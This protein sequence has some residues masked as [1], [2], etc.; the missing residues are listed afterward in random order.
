MKTV[1]ALICPLILAASALAVPP[2]LTL[3][4]EV[5]GDVTA[6]IKI[7]AVTTGKTVQW[8]A[9]DPGLNVFP[10][11]QLKDTKT[12]IVTSARAGRYRMLAYTALADEVSEPAICV[13]VVGQPPPEPGPGPGPGPTPPTPPPSPAPIP[14]AGLHVLIVENPRERANLKPEQL[15]ILF[16]KKFHDYLNSKCVD[17]AEAGRKAWNIWTEKTDVS[18]IPKK[19]Q[20]AMKR[21]RK[22]LPWIIISNPTK[23]GFEGPLPENV[24]K[25][26]ELIKKYE[27]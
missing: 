17:D 8:V 14:V 5:K 21:D 25:T 18:S 9:I 7:P 26:I 16:D 15:G 1:L 22:S 23:G 4:T 2:T 27:E 13:V 3:P 10:I 12:A 6:F 11:D 20:D 24:D 19:W